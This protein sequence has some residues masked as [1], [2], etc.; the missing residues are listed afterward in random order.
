M[1]NGAALTRACN[2]ASVIRVKKLEVERLAKKCPTPSLASCLA[3]AHVPLVSID[4]G[5]WA[6]RDEDE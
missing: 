4:A 2:P 5:D 6:D 3:M 1:G